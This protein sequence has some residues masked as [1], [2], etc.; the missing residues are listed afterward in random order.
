MTEQQ[1]QLIDGLK[2][3]KDALRYDASTYHIASTWVSGPPSEGLERVSGKLEFY[4]LDVVEMLEL[5][6]KLFQVED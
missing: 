3:L 6:K 2:S 5:A 1:Q 4:M